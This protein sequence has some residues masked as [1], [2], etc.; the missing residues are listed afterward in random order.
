ML[1]RREFPRDHAK[2]EEVGARVR[3]AS[4]QLLRRHVAGCSRR[5]PRFRQSR[6]RGEARVADSCESEVEDLDVPVC[7]PDDVLRLEISVDDA[8]R[9]RSAEAGGDLDERWDEAVRCCRGP[10]SSSSRSVSPWTSSEAMNS[11][12]SISSSAN[13]VAMDSCVNAAAARASCAADRD[14]GDRACTPAGSA[15]SATVRAE[16]LIARGVDDAH[17]AAADFLENEVGADRFP[18]RDRAR[19][20]ESGRR[21][22]PRPASREILRSTRDAEQRSNLGRQFR[23]GF[24]GSLRATLRARSRRAPA[25]RGRAH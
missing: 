25:R 7:A 8:A 21:R 14:A 20:R 24:R 1:A 16:P 17:A 5:R 15:L 13:T 3:R 10:R 22:R 19:V 11:S 9:V 4:A 18:V 6:D 2:G 12:P 23:I